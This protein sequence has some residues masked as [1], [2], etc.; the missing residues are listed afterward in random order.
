M[1]YGGKVAEQQRAREL[2][3]EA[4]TLQDIAS[5]AR[6]VEVVGVAVGP[7]RRVHAPPAERGHAR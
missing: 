6:R 5:R 3:A 7:R 2:R 1:G 4:W